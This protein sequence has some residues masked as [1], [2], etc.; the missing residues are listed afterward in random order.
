MLMVLLRTTDLCKLN[1]V[2]GGNVIALDY[3]LL[4]AVD[5]ETTRRESLK[6]HLILITV[7]SLLTA[8]LGGRGPLHC[9]LL[10]DF[11]VG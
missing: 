7:S 6:S 9:L 1:L 11:G 4:V 10:F 2:G 8:L 5:R 3:I